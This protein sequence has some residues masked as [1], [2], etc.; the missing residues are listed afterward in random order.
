MNLVLKMP[1]LRERLNALGSEPA[2][3]TPEEMTAR[4]RAES[5]M[6]ARPTPRCFGNPD[7]FHATWAIASSG[8]ETT[9]MMQFGEYFTTSS[10]TPATIPAP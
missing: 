4:I 2:G 1:E 10:V 9:M 8:F 7:F 5:R 3:S 6:P